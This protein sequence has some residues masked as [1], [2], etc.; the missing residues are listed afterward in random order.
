MTAGLKR[1]VGL[2]SAIVYGVGVI[3]GA[4]VYALIG[5][6]AELAGNTVWLSFVLAAVVSAFTGLSYMELISMFPQSAAEYIFVKNAFKNKLRARVTI[7][8]VRMHVY[9][10]SH[11][12]IT[13]FNRDLNM[14]L[15]VE[16][17]SIELR[18]SLETWLQLILV[19][20]VSG[21]LLFLALSFI[22]PLIWR[23]G[24]P[25]ID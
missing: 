10:C 23:L 15:E 3:L 16:K 5:E 9:A 18:V 12:L 17:E 22:M 21:F 11:H 4:G 14:S 24:G 7:Y 19:L 25:G 6:A 8:F 2:F 20:V 1:S 13:R